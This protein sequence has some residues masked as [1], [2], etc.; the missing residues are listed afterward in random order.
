MLQQGTKPARRTATLQINPTL[1]PKVV[2]LQEEV[3][4]ICIFMAKAV[5]TS[6]EDA[7]RITEDLAIVST[8][9]KTIDANRREFTDP[10]R[11]HEHDINDFFATTLTGPLAEAYK[12]GKRKLID[13]NRQQDIIHHAAELKARAAAASLAALTPAVQQVDSFTGEVTTTPPPLPAPILPDAPPTTV[14]TGMG[15]ASQ[16]MI[17]KVKV[18][19]FARLPDD[20]KLP[21][22]PL[23]NSMVQKGLQ[24]IPGCEIWLEPDIRI[25]RRR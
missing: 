24:R 10:L 21:N 12:A 13:F 19:D 20:Y 5:V 1:D 15:T 9:T 14:S 23:L 16:R 25:T 17:P 3:K 18:V 22:Q 8:L 7:A 2:A 4:R 6:K 11:Q